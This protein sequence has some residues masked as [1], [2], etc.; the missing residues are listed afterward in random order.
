MKVVVD[1]VRGNV[2][3][4]SETIVDEAYDTQLCLPQSET[5][6]L[7]SFLEA[8]D[9]VGDGT[10]KKGRKGEHYEGTTVWMAHKPHRRRKTW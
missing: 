4:E 2:N 5:E 10:P 9:A 1:H 6:F 3:N 7:E 8:M